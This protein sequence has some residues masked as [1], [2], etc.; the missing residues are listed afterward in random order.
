MSKSKKPAKRSTSTPAPARKRGGTT[1]EPVVRRRKIKQSQKGHPHT[2]VSGKGVDQHPEKPEP[3]KTTSKPG[4]DDA[5]TQAFA[6]WQSGTQLSV[7]AARLNMKRSRLRRSFTLLA[8]GKA[9]FKAMRSEGA[10]GTAEPFGGKRATGG[11]RAEVVAADDKKVPIIDS[12]KAS[13]GWSTR[14]IWQP[15]NVTIKDVGTVSARELAAIVHI[16]PD[17]TEYVECRT[18]SEKADFRRESPITPGTFIRFRK[19]ES[20]PVAKKVAHHEKLVERGEKSLERTRTRK[21]AA[22]QARTSRRK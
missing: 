18:A 12:M 22:K 4:A 7:L 17:G 5:T 3:K 21:R 11:K 14:R 6:D 1:P 20:S 15:R 9:Q 2:K 19:F 13:D 8:G 16:S 10:G